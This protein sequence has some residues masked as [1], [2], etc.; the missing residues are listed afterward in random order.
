MDRPPPPP[1]GGLSGNAFYYKYSDILKQS[2]S[3]DRA[4]PDILV[5]H[6]RLSPS[7]RVK[8]QKEAPSATCLAPNVA[9]VDATNS[10]FWFLSNTER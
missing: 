9:T 2:R 1:G 5:V 10:T 7:I 4:L 6:P 3:T 8:R